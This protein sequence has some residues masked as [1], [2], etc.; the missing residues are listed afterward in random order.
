LN[1][2]TPTAPEIKMSERLV[3]D[4]MTKKYSVIK[5]SDIIIM[6]PDTKLAREPGYKNKGKGGGK[7]PARN[8][9][10][11]DTIKQIAKISSKVKKG[12]AECEDLMNQITTTIFDIA[13]MLKEADDPPEEREHYL[14]HY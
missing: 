10:S 1:A 8:E 11:D 7:K 14:H 2:P 6:S 4:T 3:F 13:T 12:V 9:M 5:I